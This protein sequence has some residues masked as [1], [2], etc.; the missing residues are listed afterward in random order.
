MGEMTQ[1]NY[2]FP[3]FSY[4]KKWQFFV[5]NTHFTPKRKSLQVFWSPIV[6]LKKSKSLPPT[7]FS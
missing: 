3:I 7:L 5:K 4:S 6:V 2:V 1:P